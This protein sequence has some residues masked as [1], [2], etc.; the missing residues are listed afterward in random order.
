MPLTDCEP[1][2]V[3]NR[4]MR[5]SVNWGATLYAGVAAGVL[6]TVVQIALWSTF[7]DALPS[8]LFRDARFAAAIVM[9]RAV[10]PPPATFEWPVMLVVTLVHF[11][12]SITYGLSVSWVQRVCAP[13]HPF[14]SEPYLT[15]P[16]MG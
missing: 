1:A 6:A 15:S 12:L 13:C 2:N 10:L 16:C 11:A 14:S 3:A 4:P 7:G 8:I 9:G 5:Y